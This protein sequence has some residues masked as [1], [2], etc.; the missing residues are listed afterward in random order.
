MS[1]ENVFCYLVGTAGSG[2]TT[3]TQGFDRAL[4][5]HGLDSIMVNL[6]PGAETLPYTPDVDIRDW[7]KLS[8]IMAEHGLGP[9]GAQIAAADMLAVNLEEVQEEIETF[10]ADYVLLDTPGQIELFVFRESGRYLV[11]N[12]HKDRSMVAYL[13]DPFLART[14]NGFVSQ[15]MLG[16]T[17]TFR[18]DVPMQ[19]V[20]SKAD[21]LSFEDLDKIGTWAQNQDALY[22]AVVGE[23]PSMQQQFSTDLIRALGDLGGYPGV[24]PVSSSSGEGFDDLYNAIQAAFFG[25]ED[26]LSD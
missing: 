3:M 16:A 25:S 11:H 1:K 12:L 19:A 14:P 20:L 10:K 8:E 17:T 26:L 13:M 7:I 15:L 18:L 23:T 22:D 6:D 2:K 21:V 24:V 5:Q 9:N 4:K